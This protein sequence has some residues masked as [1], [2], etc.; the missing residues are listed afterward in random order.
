MKVFLAGLCLLAGVDATPTFDEF[1]VT[2]KFTGKPL[3]PVLRSRMQRNFRTVIRDA[4]NAGP[5][6]AGH[7]TLAEWGCGAGCVSMAIVDSRTGQTFDGPFSV[8]GYDLSY[9][10]GG[11]E[12]LEYRIDSRLILA[13]GCPGEKDC[14]TYY[15]EWT[16]NQFKLIRKVPASKRSVSFRQA[17]MTRHRACCYG[18]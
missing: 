4:A 8:L 6:F 14:G 1:K 13:R 2:E 7:Y 3:A 5:N 18:R 11:D 15:Y 9:S 16:A 12:Q 17:C 10:Y